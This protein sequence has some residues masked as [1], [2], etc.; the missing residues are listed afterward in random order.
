MTVIAD[1]G[2]LYALIDASDAWH[3]RVAAWWANNAAPVVVPIT[4]VPELTYLVATRIGP[5]AECAVVRAVADGEFAIEEVV[6]ED[7]APTAAL[8]ERYS[9]LALG[10]VDASVVVMAERLAAWQV[11]TTDRRHF[12]AI[13]SSKGRALQLAP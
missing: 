1:T 8:M 2:A 12:S 3:K 10:F 9:D 7:W 11:L 5:H 6:Q 13:R 4:V